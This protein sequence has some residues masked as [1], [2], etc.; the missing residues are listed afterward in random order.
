MRHRY[1][2]VVKENETLKSEQ[3]RRMESYMR[4]ETN[5]QAELEDLKAEV[6]RREM[7]ADEKESELM[8]KKNQRRRDKLVEGCQGDE[9]NAC[10]AVKLAVVGGGPAGVT[11]AIYA[12]RAGLKPLVVAPAMGGQLMSKGVNV[13]NYPGTRPAA[14]TVP[15]SHR[16]LSLQPLTPPNM[17]E[18]FR[19]LR[20][21]SVRRR[22]EELAGGQFPLSLLSYPSRWWTTNKPTV[23]MTRVYD[24][25]M[26]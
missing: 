23:V 22:F 2:E 17:F 21:V 8:G 5:Y 7:L 10:K 20:C 16:A 13:E 25:Y 14:R 12:A 3:K 4:R 6:Y 1:E 15:S 24:R 9:P 11:A 26:T 19:Q 18:P